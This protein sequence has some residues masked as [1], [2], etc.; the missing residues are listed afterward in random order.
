MRIIW[1]ITGAGHLI[2]ESIDV[3]E[4]ISEEHEIT[5]ITS[6][7]GEEVLQLYGYT[8]TINNIIT[9]NK[10][11]QLIKDEDQQYSYPF[12]GKITEY[13]YDLIIIAPAT[14][15]TTAKIVH[16]IA[17]TLITNVAAQS[18]K[19]RIPLLI[20]PVDQK[21]GLLQTQIPPY[22]DKKLCKKH[23]PCYANRYCPEDAIHPP[24]IDATKCTSCKKC[25]KKCPENAIITDKIIEIYIRKIDADNAKHLN[26]IENI[27][28]LEK[29]EE[30]LEK[31]RKMEKN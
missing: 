7:A 12:S 22:I 21:E 8:N 25:E 18:G 29:P 4:K 11:N 19:G 24:K 16:G 9:K 15:N 26:D 5:I 14:A 30:I 23:D 3:L 20:I 28:T 31:I 17:D 27:T 6:K 2:K 13:K 1:A 10:N